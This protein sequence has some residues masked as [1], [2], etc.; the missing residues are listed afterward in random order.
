MSICG[1]NVGAVIEG[2]SRKTKCARL[3]IAVQDIAVRRRESP[4]AFRI[5]HFSAVCAERKLPVDRGLK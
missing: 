3:E 2:D 1:L 5:P 4:S